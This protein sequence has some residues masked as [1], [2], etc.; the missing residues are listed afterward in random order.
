MRG[1]SGSARQRQTRQVK[2][3]S[4]GR[5]DQQGRQQLDL[6]MHKKERRERELGGMGTAESC[7]PIKNIGHD[8]SEGEKIGAQ[9]NRHAGV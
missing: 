5:Q 7:A 2:A 1:R 9:A 4:R 3:D 8:A 6:G